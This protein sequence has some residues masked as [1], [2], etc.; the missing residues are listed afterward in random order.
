MHWVG[1]CIVI[2]NCLNDVF[3]SIL[4]LVSISYVNLDLLRRSSELVGGCW[5]MSEV[6]ANGYER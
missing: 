2:I 6:V 5:C 1:G 3:E 4:N